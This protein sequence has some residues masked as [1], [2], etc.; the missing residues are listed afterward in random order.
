MATKREGAI[1]RKARMTE[2]MPQMPKAD[3]LMAAGYLIRYSARGR[4]SAG[5]V[6]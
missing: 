6:T 1:S 3:W 5:I 4:S 2:T